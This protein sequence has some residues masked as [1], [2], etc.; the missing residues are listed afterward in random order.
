[1]PNASGVFG[2]NNNGGVG[3]SGISDLGTGVAGLSKQGDAVL[4][5][6]GIGG[7]AIHGRG[8]IFAGFFEGGVKIQGGSLEVSKV[9]DIG[10][11]I[12]AQSIFAPNKHFIIDH[13]CDPENKYLIHATVESSERMNIYSGVVTLGQSGEAVVELPEWFEALNCDFRYQ[14]TC[15]GGFSPVYVAGKVAGNRFK[16]AGGHLGLEVSWQVAGIRKDRLA[17]EHPLGSGKN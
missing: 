5:Q 14:L 15:I 2:A 6:A 8:G 4:G 7:N 17:L 10:G 11:E 3:V 13:P 16:I 9:G 12:S 1:V